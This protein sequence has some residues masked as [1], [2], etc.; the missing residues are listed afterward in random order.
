MSQSIAMEKAF[1]FA[2]RIIK[3]YK[4]LCDE[5]NEYVLSKAVLTS[6]TYIGKHIKE[7][8]NGESRQ[9]FIG[10]MATALKRASETEYWLKLLRASEYLDEKAFL[11]INNDCQELQRILTS[12]INTSKSRTE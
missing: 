6:G 3:L 1:A 2:L 8:L 5:K 9:V 4:F 11:S 7:A 12:F 10:A